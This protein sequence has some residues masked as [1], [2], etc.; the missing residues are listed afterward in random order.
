MIKIGYIYKLTTPDDKIYIGKTQNIVKRYYKYK[1]CVEHGLM[2]IEVQKWGWDNINKEILYEG[3][4]NEMLFS[5]LEKHYIRLFNTFESN[6][7]LNSQSGGK[8]GFKTSKVSTTKMSKTRTGTKIAEETKIKM[9]KIRTGKRW[10]VKDPSRMGGKKG[11]GI[12]G[13]LVLDTETG[14][15]YK[16]IAEASKCLGIKR[17]TLN[18]K[19]LGVN[20]NNTSIKYV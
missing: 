6:N 5:D 9:S 8:S 18:S 17:T 7:G 4:Y 2:Y 10:K 3:E 15:Y 19:L 14:I 12:S 20:P 13:T 16:S 1:K 11:V